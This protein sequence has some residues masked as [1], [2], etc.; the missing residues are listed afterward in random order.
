MLVALGLARWGFFDRRQTGSE[1]LRQLRE[2][3]ASLAVYSLAGALALT[4]LAATILWAPCGALRRFRTDVLESVAP[5]FQGLPWWKIAVIAGAAGLGE[6]F[7]FRWSI[8]GG[9]GAVG[10]HPWTALLVASLVFGLCHFL[11]ALYALYAA[12]A[13]LILG[14]LMQFSGSVWPSVA[15][16]SLYDLAAILYLVRAGR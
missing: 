11:S 4:F 3:S 14:L 7:L 1:L 9:L 15:A 16:H 10:W 5:L 13:G 2:D 12:T 8:Q 6:E